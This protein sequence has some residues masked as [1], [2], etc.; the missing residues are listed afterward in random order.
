MEAGDIRIVG[1]HLANTREELERLSKHID[2]RFDRVEMKQDA[3]NGRLGSL[4]SYRA[5]VTGAV[6]VLLLLLGA[7]A[8]WIGLLATR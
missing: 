8:G 4:E 3:T 2:T 5:A 1:E 6:A 7:A